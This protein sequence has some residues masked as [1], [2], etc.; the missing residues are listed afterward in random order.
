MLPKKT[1]NCNVCNLY[2]ESVFCV[3]LTK[4]IVLS[5]HFLDALFNLYCIVLNMV[6]Y[7]VMYLSFILFYKWYK[8]GKLK[9]LVVFSFKMILSRYKL[10]C[11]LCCQNNYYKFDKPKMTFFLRLTT[12]FFFPY[13]PKWN[14]FRN[15]W[16]INLLFRK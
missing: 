5:C 11:T 4:K 14:Y 9:I 16:I 6:I 8:S 7:L 13:W 3:N 15:F 1:F 12:N 10:F 2:T